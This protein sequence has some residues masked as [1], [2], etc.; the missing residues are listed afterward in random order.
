MAMWVYRSDRLIQTKNWVGY[1]LLLVWFI[2]CSWHS[3]NKH[4]ENRSERKPL[5]CTTISPD[6]SWNKNGLQNAFQNFEHLVNMRRV[7]TTVFG[8]DSKTRWWLDDPKSAVLKNWNPKL[9][10][11]HFNQLNLAKKLLNFLEMLK[12]DMKLTPKW[13]QFDGRIRNPPQKNKH[14]QV[15][16][17]TTVV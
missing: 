2:P 13:Y 3:R 10:P 14:Q 16:L 6:I 17:S 12:E 4:A 11:S 1:V 5:D 7:L 8:C 9:D 15:I